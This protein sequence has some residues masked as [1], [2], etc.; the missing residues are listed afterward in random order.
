VQKEFKCRETN[1]SVILFYG[2]LIVWLLI[3]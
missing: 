2:Y 1:V 3:I